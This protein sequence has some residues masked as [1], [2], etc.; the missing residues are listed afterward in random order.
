MT[1]RKIKRAEWY[2]LLRRAQENEIEQCRQT[3]MDRIFPT[4]EKSSP[5]Y[6]PVPPNRDTK[7][8]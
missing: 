6:V 5:H 2:D 1:T 3:I 7:D 4:R 8:C